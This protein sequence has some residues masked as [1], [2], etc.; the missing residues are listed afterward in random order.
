MKVAITG[1]TGGLGLAFF[2]YFVQKNYQVVGFSRSNGYDISKQESRNKILDIVKDFD[3]FINNAFNN[4]DDSQFLML[5]LIYDLWK[6]QNKT[7]INISSRY[8][9]DNNI[10]CKVKLALDDYCHSKSYGYPKII[11]LKPGLVDTNRVINIKREKIQ[12]EEVVKVLD[13]ALANNIQSVTFGK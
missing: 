10:Y 11:N 12:V 6:D 3:F 8:T 1:H 5:S 2:N 7:I 13:F 4:W 9:K